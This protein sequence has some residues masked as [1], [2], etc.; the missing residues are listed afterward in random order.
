VINLKQALVDVIADVEREA[1]NDAS[2]DS[3]L[4][5][6]TLTI[7]VI[8]GNMLT[9]AN[10]GDSRIVLGTVNPLT[11]KLMAERLTVDHKPDLP[12]ENHRILNSGGRVFSIEYD[13]GIV[14]PPRVWLANLKLPGLAMSRSLCDKIAH[15]AGVSSEPD[16]LERTLS[17]NN[18]CLLILATDGLWEFMKDQVIT[19]FQYVISVYQCLITTGSY[20]HRN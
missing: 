7:A 6:T 20:R 1:L 2:I 17:E 16:I 11:G 9:T 4:S 18:D 3:K 5:G 13:D 15:M 8:R 19:Y 10:V 14:G 12:L